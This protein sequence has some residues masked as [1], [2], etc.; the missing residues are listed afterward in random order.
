MALRGSAALRR[1]LHWFLLLRCHLGPWPLGPP[2]ALATGPPLDP[3]PWAPL[4]PWPLGPP[5]A[6]AIGPPVGPGPL[7]PPWALAL[8][9]PLGPG[10]W[11]PLG[12]W[13]LGPPWALATGPPLGPGHWSRA[14]GPVRPAGFLIFFCFSKV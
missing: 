11:A 5:W 6:L 12:P 10:P 8:G 14:L 13:P 2:W 7:G 3:G 1:N 4:G 9:P